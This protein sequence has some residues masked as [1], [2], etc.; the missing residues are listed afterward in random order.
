MTLPAKGSTMTH[1]PAPRV[2]V[3]EDLRSVVLAADVDDDRT[4]P[5][6]T[7]ASTPE[8]PGPVSRELTPYSRSGETTQKVDLKRR[9]TAGARRGI[10][11]E[12]VLAVVAVVTAIVLFA[13]VAWMIVGAG[14]GTAAA[15]AAGP[16][17]AGSARRPPRALD[18]AEP[19]VDLADLPVERE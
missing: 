3:E 19:A 14:G 18:G 6:G 5:R 7:A 8:E 13:F 17:G 4:P 10:A 12:I 11:P 15:P 2:V 1:A 9:A 16:S